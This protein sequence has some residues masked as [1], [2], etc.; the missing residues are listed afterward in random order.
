MVPVH[1]PFIL[2]E[3]L[4][5]AVFWVKYLAQIGNGREKYGKRS[6]VISLGENP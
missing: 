3:L 1:K 2:K 5:D 6:E 4:R